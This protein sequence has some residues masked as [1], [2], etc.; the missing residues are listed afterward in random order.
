MPGRCAAPPLRLF[1]I[2][3]LFPG[4][5]LYGVL[6][7]VIAQLWLVATGIVMLR[8]APVAPDTAGTA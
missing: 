7:S 5:L 4:F 6:G 8:C 2:P 3:G 1:L